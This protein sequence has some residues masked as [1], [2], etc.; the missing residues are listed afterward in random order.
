[1]PKEF[2]RR[3]RDFVTQ[4]D[5]DIIPLQDNVM[6]LY[7]NNDIILSSLHYPIYSL[8]LFDT[9]AILTRGVVLLYCLRSPFTSRIE[10]LAPPHPHRENKRFS[11]EK[12][13]VFAGSNAGTVNTADAIAISVLGA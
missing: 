4:A 7:V 10:T 3:L 2:R 8:I 9:W 6:I 13:Q 5:N 12:I 11:S 1:M